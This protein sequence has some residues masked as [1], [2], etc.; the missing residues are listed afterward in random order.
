M[1]YAPTM[2]RGVVYAGSN[3]RYVHALNAENGELLWS[4]NTWSAVQSSP[5]VID[6][7]VYVSTED[8]FVYALFAFDP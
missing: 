2:A 7:R 5:T 1:Y 4:S 8:G 6:G 3:T